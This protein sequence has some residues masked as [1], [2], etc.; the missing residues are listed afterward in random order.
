MLPD[1][2]VAVQVT[3][4]VPTGKVDPDGGLH[5][6]VGA[7]G[8]LSVAIGVTYV[9]VDVVVNGQDACAAL[10]IPAGQPFGNTGGC[11]SFTVT[12]KLHIDILFDESLTTHATVVLPFGK[13]PPDA[14]VHI[15]APTPGQLSLTTGAG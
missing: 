9:I 1:E 4:V 7:G 2:S 5:T 11:V 8:Q 15:G 3:D 12:R 10:T 6:T 14:G 13:T